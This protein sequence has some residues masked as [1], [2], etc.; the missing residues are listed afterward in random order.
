MVE[1]VEG[2]Y[3]GKG[4]SVGIL[5]AEF[6]SQVTEP[7]KEGALR[8]LRRAGVEENDI[9][10]YRVPGGFE[11]PGTARRV[12]ERKDHDGLLCLGAI[13]RGETPHFDHLSSTVTQHLGRLSY[14]A[15]VPVVNGVLT[16][17]TADQ[18]IRRAGVKEGN[19]GAEAALTL[20]HML[21]LYEN[22]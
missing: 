10:V 15:D 20:L 7:L 21:N 18:A 22:V 2:S 1:R 11:L 14:E 3:E 8:T 17:D 6:N 19:R 13:I 9:T 5:L 16:T 4:F 12:R